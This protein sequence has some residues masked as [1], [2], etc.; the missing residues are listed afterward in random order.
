MPTSANP[1]IQPSEIEAARRQLPEPV[2]QQEYEA[3]FLEDGGAVLRNVVKC[4]TDESINKGLPDNNYV[5]GVD[6]GRDEDFTVFSVFDHTTRSQVRIERSTGIEY[7]QQ[8]ERLLELCRKFSPRAVVAEQN[9]IGI[10]IIEELRRDGLPLR[11]FTM[12]NSTKAVLV[13]SLALAFEQTSLTILADPCRG[14]PSVATPAVDPA[15][16]AVQLRELQVFTA[17]RLPSGL[18][19]YAAPSGFHDDTV[20]ALMLSYD[21]RNIPAKAELGDRIIWN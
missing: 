16:A 8:R 11:P 3:C 7:R 14:G 13:D 10:P 20:I 21:S 2:F 4:A 5:I 12:T 6:W 15:N 17:Q 19:R 1:Y 18:I 9:S